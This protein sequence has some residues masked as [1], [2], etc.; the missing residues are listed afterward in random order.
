MRTVAIG[1]VILV[2]LC[3]TVAAGAGA[4]L[5]VVGELAHL[6]LRE[7]LGVL[8]ADRADR[9]AAD[10]QLGEPRVARLGE[11]QAADQRFAAARPE[12]DHLVGRP[13]PPGPVRP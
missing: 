12:P 4:E 11:E 5:L 9:A 13:R 2:E 3:L 10:L 7:F 1:A 8:T 6:R